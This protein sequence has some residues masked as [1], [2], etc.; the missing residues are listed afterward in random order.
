MNV[1]RHVVTDLLPLYLSGEAHADT[2][3]LV[4]EY[5]RG[6]PEFAR[7]VEK[8]RGPLE[9]WQA[10]PE[11]TPDDAAELALFARA[12]SAVQRGVWRKALALTGVALLLIGAGA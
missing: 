8:Q 5:L 3:S 7:L 12:R 6:D 4:D 10:P 1:N 11:L 2:R 9:R